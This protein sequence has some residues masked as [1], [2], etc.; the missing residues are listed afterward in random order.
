MFALAL[1]SQVISPLSDSILA[2]KTVTVLDDKVTI[3]D[4]GVQLVA[5]LS[6]SLLPSPADSR[7][8]YVTTTAQDLLHTPK[9]VTHRKFSSLI[10]VCA[11]LGLWFV[12]QGVLFFFFNG[13]MHFNHTL[14]VESLLCWMA[15]Q[16][17]SLLQKKNNTLEA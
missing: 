16:G 4:L 8:I 6:L 10:F 13:V 9:Q 1:V 2:E 14:S 5:S 11:C 12:W 3:S 15:M 7:A 17:A